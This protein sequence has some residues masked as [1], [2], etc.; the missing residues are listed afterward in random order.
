MD[1]KVPVGW[2]SANDFEIFHTPV[3]SRMSSDRLADILHR[4]DLIV[5]VTDLTRRLS[6][7]HEKQFIRDFYL[8]GR[9]ASSLVVVV[10]GMELVPDQPQKLAIV[11]EIQQNL[12]TLLSS[13]QTVTAND[14]PSV[15]PVSTR[16]ARSELP[17]VLAKHFATGS[18]DI[19]TA[20]GLPALQSTVISRVDTARDRAR[21]KLSTAAFSATQA[22]NH[23]LTSHAAAQSV[24]SHI[25]DDLQVLVDRVVSTEKRLVREYE[26]RD[27]GVVEKTFTALS[28]AIRAYFAS[29][30][31]WKLFWKSETVGSDLQ[32]VVRDHSLVQSEYQMVYAI[33]KMNE[34][35][36][37]LYERVQE[38][39]QK[40]SHSCS[41][42]ACLDA[43]KRLNEDLRRGIVSLEA[44]SPVTG[45]ADPFILRNP[46]AQFDTSYSAPHC[47]ALQEVAQKL[48]A[49]QMVY[50]LG[51]FFTLA[52]VTHLGVPFAA[53]GLPV[54]IL[55]STTGLVWMNMRWKRAEER[56]WAGVSAGFGRL[57]ENLVSTYRQEFQRTVAAP[58]VSVV[59]TLEQ[60]L[61]LSQKQLEKGRSDVRET[62]D[63]VGWI[64]A[65]GKGR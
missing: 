18:G 7:E 63:R 28:D 32:R 19:Y 57:R 54:S 38:S 64:V 59:Q 48:V 36:V 55:A 31:F 34:G 42:D 10:D 44:R 15:I 29:A 65:D 50:Q 16:A 5:L 11:D 3:A 27:L 40:A 62:L 24:L 22:L 20:S 46:V 21:L 13:S 58:L 60:S 39:L 4:T 33:G 9:T 26:S 61:Q 49:R 17:A 1:A 37:Q 51:I 47:K 30:R 35:L 41:Q 53:V 6:T 56:F 43:V 8:N 12:R 52:G 23:L 25:T 14:I 45:E 2:L